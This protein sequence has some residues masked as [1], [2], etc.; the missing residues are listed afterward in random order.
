MIPRYSKVVDNPRSKHFCCCSVKLNAAD[1]SKK[2]HKRTVH[3]VHPADGVYESCTSLAF[4][5][6]GVL[7]GTRINLEVGISVR[8]TSLPQQEHSTVFHGFSVYIRRQQSLCYSG[9]NTKQKLNYE[10]QAC[11]QM[12]VTMRGRIPASHDTAQTCSIY[13]ETPAM[14]SFLHCRRMRGKQKT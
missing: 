9:A 11:P 6:S 2:L 5:T 14:Q 1:L 12:D 3:M 4:A 13:N 10:A 7:K 8:T